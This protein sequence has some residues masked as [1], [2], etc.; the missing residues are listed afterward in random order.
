MFFEKSQV[1]FEGG[2]IEKRISGML[3][4]SF[5]EIDLFELKKICLALES[6]SNITQIDLATIISVYE[7]HSIFSIFQDH[8]EV[9]EQI[10]LQLESKE[11]PK[12]QNQHGDDAE[13][14][15]LRRLHRVLTMPTSDWKNSEKAR[16]KVIRDTRSTNCC[17]RFYIWLRL[18]IGLGDGINI[19]GSIGFKT[20]RQKSLHFKSSRFR[21][22]LME[23]SMLS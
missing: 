18:K 17:K 10:Q 15:F 21:E 5:S 1:R 23:I 3:F 16:N 2:K 8:I 4:R 22:N 14:G 9:Y 7:G 6:R 19:D 12:E 11:F 20:V 13:N